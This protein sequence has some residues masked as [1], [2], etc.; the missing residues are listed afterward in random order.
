MASR[1]LVAAGN[2]T[3]KA[4]QLPESVRALLEGAGEILVVS[5]ALPDRFH[6][7][8]SDTDKARMAADERLGT[9]LGHLEQLGREAKGE[10][11]ADD[12]LLAFDDAVAEFGPDHIL[13]GLRS[14]SR[15]GWQEHHLIEQVL[16][17][18]RLPVTV[19]VT[20]DSA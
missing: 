13:I 5:P 4:D 17:R 19:F 20:E 8:S 9:V 16:E 18:F 14:P 6:W 7:L 3:E 10:V 2:V 12:P 11:G 15:S 1:L